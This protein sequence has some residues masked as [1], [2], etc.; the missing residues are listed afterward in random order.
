MTFAYCW[1]RPGRRIRAE[2]FACRYCGVA[3]EECPGVAWRNSC[4]G[5]ALCPCEG[6]GWVA[7]VR[8]KRCAFAQ[9]ISSEAVME[10]AA[11]DEAAVGSAS[12][13]EASRP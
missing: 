12:A 9:A 5:G 6:S 4:V 2:V 13:S 1:H 11:V 8:S 10:A 7:I 3:I